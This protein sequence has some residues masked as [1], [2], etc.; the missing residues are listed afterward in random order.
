M[1]MQHV[2]I[3]V[4]VGGGAVGIIGAGFAAMVFTLK[5]TM[6]EEGFRLVRPILHNGAIRT[7]SKKKVWP[8]PKKES[9]APDGIYTTFVTTFW[10]NLWGSKGEQIELKENDFLVWE[11]LDNSE[12][13]IIIEGI[14]NL[15]IQAI[16]ENK[17]LKQQM[18]KLRLVSVKLASE[19][20]KLSKRF[21]ENV[22]AR[23]V[24]LVDFTKAV[25]PYIDYKRMEKSRGGSK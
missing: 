11:G 25:N 19:Y 21:N 2:I 14:E 17:Q 6:G 22:D 9:S 15:K 16:Q 7:K 1:S 18:E 24:Q 23:V 20:R 12:D 4:I 5:K 10:T 13:T 8:F 3:G